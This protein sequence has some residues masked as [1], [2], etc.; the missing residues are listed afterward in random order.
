MLDFITRMV[1]SSPIE[2]VAVACGLINV[3][4]IVRRSIWNYPFGF[5]MVLL[6]A[7]IFYDYRL[8]SDALLQIYFF[9][10]QFY[11]LYC[12][13]KGRGL[14]GKV[15]VGSMGWQGL[16]LWLAVT[17]ACWLVLSVLMDRFTDASLPYWDGAIAALSMLAQ[18]LLSRRYIESWVFWITVDVLAIGLFSVKGLYPTA[19]LYGVFLVLAITGLLQWRQQQR[20]AHV[21]AVA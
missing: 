4:L 19:A 21:T 13:L 14:D 17:A 16:A 11:G 7:R 18:F 10:I 6:Y 12:W 5:V 1:G 8:Y 3:V 9:F 2:V 15:E 20:P